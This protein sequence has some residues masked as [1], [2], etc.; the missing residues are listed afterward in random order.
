M[1]EP[2][3]V[4]YESIIPADSECVLGADIGGTNSNFGVFLQANFG[5]PILLFSLHYKSQQITD[6]IDVI[7]DVLCYCKKHHNITIIAA[8]FAAA[9]AIS[10]HNASVKPTNLSFTIHK[11]DIIQSTGLQTVLLVNDFA[12]IGYGVDVLPADQLV[13]IHKGSARQ[14]ANKII[15]GAGTGLGKCVMVWDAHANRYVP[16]PSEGGHADCAVRTAVEFQL[17]QHM[18][19]HAGNDFP[20]SWEDILSGNGI[21]SMYQFFHD[22]DGLAYDGHEEAP[23]P[24]EIFS[25]KDRDKSCRETVELYGRMY[26]R[27]AKN[28]ALDA[29]ALSGVYIAG[30]IAAKNIPLFQ[31]PFFVQ[32]FTTNNK[33]KSLLTEIPLYVIVDYNVSLYGAVRYL[34]LT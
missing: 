20:V 22:G 23:H 10:S 18:Q 24:D 9:G 27:C 3:I 26:A 4:Y 16:S 2:R 32:E 7:N 15:L 21:R 1:N 8:C 29:L 28:F 12:V 30:G 11:K 25:Q 31:E 14:K 33:Q 17:L 34:Y 6:F 19:K 13:C 5:H